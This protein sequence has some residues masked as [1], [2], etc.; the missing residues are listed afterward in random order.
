M[1]KTIITTKV[2]KGKITI[3]LLENGYEDLILGD[4]FV[5]MKGNKVVKP[6]FKPG[7]ESADFDGLGRVIDSYDVNDINS[8]VHI[9]DEFM[10]DSIKECTLMLKLKMEELIRQI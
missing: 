1:S 6:K 2:S 3:E 7:K 9:C 4:K 8:I 5:Y 10:Y